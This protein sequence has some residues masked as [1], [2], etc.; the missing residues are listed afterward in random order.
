MREKIMFR[1]VFVLCCLLT[2]LSADYTQIDWLLQG[3]VSYFFPSEDLFREI[4]GRGMPM[5]GAVAGAFWNDWGVTATVD[6]LNKSGHSIGLANPT[7]IDLIP[8][9]L[10]VVYRRPVLNGVEVFGAIGPEIHYIRFHD[11]NPIFFEHLNKWGYGGIARAGAWLD[12]ANF[13]SL[14][15]S[16]AYAI[17]HAYFHGCSNGIKKQSVNSSGWEITAALGVNF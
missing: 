7:H 8:I 2:S 3:R 15:L 1:L 4:Y 16:G 5:Y 14:E 13:V 9:S 11:K 12:V 6:V 17:R 10:D